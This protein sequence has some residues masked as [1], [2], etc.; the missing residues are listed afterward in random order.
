MKTKTQLI[1]TIIAFFVVSI[2]NAQNYTEYFLTINKKEPYKVTVVVHFS[3]KIDTLSIHPACPNYDYPHGWSTFIKPISKNLTYIGDSKWHVTN[4]KK[5]IYEVDL[6]FVNKIWEVGNEQAGIYLGN[7][8]FIVTRALFLIP[9]NH[10]EFKVTFDLPKEYSI[11]APWTSISENSFLVNSLKELN[12]NTLVWGELKRESIKV[13]NFNLQFVLLGYEQ[14]VRDIVRETFSAIL[15]EYLEIF[16]NTPKSNYLITLFPFEQNDGEA[17]ESSNAFTLKLPP[18]E[19]NKIIWVNQFA[20]ELFHFWNGRMINGPERSKRQWFSEGFTEYFANLTLIRSG[21]INENQFYRLIEKTIGLYFYYINRQYPDVSLELAGS[22]KSKYRFGVYNGGWCA[23]F[24]MDM[25]IR[26]KFPNKSLD[27]FMSTLFTKY[28]L[29]GEPYTL[30]D[31]VR[32]FNRFIEAE[33][34]I[35]FKKYIYGLE[36]LPVEEYFKKMGISLDYT[37]YEGIAFLFDIVN[38]EKR[39][40]LLK[41][42]WLKK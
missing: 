28:G 3:E 26:E 38:S 14:S 41:N 40:L 19:Q 32:E 33:N 7:S 36:V 39:Q 21:V 4:K 12:N 34:D 29:T 8:M 2:L 10:N 17:Y 9:S 31:L 16:P 27:D 30:E 13:N 24:V 20:H 22:K 15:K 1:L 11:A 23:A 42:Q 18:T 37:Y 25:M 5:I 6:S 35:Y